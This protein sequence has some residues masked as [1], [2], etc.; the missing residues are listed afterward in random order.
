MAF[1]WKATLAAVAPLLGTAV[2]G[3]FGALAGQAV[4][5]A[6]G[7]SSTDEADLSAALQKATPEQLLALKQADNQFKLDMAKLGFR[8][9]EL[10]VEDRKSARDS[11]S[12]T[13]DNMVPG[14]AFV[15]VG[16]FVATIAGV[17]FGNVKVD[18]ALAGALVG[19]LTGAA[20]QVLAFYFGSSK[21]SKTKD[22]A[23]ANAV[24][25]SMKR[26]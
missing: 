22:D 14:L 24:L 25:V 11:Y 21:G 20:T 10:E 1:D 15:V 8:P 7:T 17:L 13:K 3:P 2:G 23:L 16:G 12:A 26:K 4:A 9:E 18:G 19:Y 5:V 6:L